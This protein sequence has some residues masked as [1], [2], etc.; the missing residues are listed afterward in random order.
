MMTARTD[1]AGQSSARP[2]PAVDLRE[3]ASVFSL[4]QEEMDEAFDLT[5]DGTPFR[6]EQYEVYQDCD[7]DD[8]VYRSDSTRLQVV[9][10]YVRQEDGWDAGGEDDEGEDL[11]EADDD[12]PKVGSGVKIEDLG[13]GGKLLIDYWVCYERGK[14]TGTFLLVD[15]DDIMLGS[16]GICSTGADPVLTQS[17]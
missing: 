17:E 10:T 15:S 5:I 16:R 14:E 13:A 8:L 11:D 2:K 3:L 1:E 4:D 12:E 7:Q 6:F 9:F